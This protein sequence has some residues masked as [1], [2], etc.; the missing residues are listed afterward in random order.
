[1]TTVEFLEGGMLVTFS[2]SWVCSVAKML[3]TRV[4]AGKSIM[5]V[6]LVCFGYVL[7][8]S[9]KLYAWHLTGHI[10]TLVYVYSWN[11]LVTTF[12]AL[13]VLRYSAAERTPAISRSVAETVR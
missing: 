5:F 12:D 13:L 3:K 9:S 2:V 1:M 4:A 8:L 7:G 11:L 6:T 10:S